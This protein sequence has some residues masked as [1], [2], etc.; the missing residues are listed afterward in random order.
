MNL[1]PIP[2]LKPRSA[3]PMLAAMLFCGFALV[4][5]ADEKQLNLY[6]WADY[7]AKDT[8]PNFE[9][10]SGIHVRYDVY[11][12]D[13]TLQAKLLTGSTGYD[14]VVP[15]S[16]FLAKQI[17]AG[18]YQKLDKS[19]LPNLAN[20]DPT[21]LKLVADADPGNQ[22]GVPWAWGTT[23]LGY[24][25]TRV[26]KILGNDAPLDNWD[27]LFKPEYL[28]KLKSC[29]VSVL[30]APADVFAVT[31][32]YLGKNPNSEV[33]SDYQAAYEALK[34]I[35]P[36]ITQFN[37]TSYINDLAG[38]DICF[39]LSWSGDVSMASHRAREANKSYEV[40]Y[41]IPKDGAPVWFDMMA[42]PKDAP[43]PE[44]A[45]DWINYIERPEVHAGITNEVFYPNANV[46]ARKFVRAEILNNPTVYPPESVVKTLFLLKPLPAS[47][48]RL[49]N[50][51][52]AQL[53]AGR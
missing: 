29:G 14:V 26:K 52:W 15:T 5:H 9:K 6:N 51:L 48:Q 13:E 11:D 49:E 39:A 36:Y 22:Y 4:A 20:L 53:K 38:D 30:D 44:A 2:I 24:N 42:I 7:I 46:A 33:P 41:F 31:L 10:E 43:H 8:V 21:L 34:Q 18:V 16:N 27:N 17:E 40:K 37:A 50:R 12:G 35:R 3:A 45:L 1:M 25:V 23:G 47:I 19:K 32:H 28:S